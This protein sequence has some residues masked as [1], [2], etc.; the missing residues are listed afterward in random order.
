VVL[1]PDRV[2]T[3]PELGVWIS[4][5]LRHGGVITPPAHFSVLGHHRDVRTSINGGALRLLAPLEFSDDRCV[6]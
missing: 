4:K 5:L 3:D 1:I 6:G 2:G